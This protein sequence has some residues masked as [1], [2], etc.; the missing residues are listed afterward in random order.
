MSF[1]MRRL[2][3]IVLVLGGLFVAAP[4]AG[5]RF[6][7]ATWNVETAFDTIPAPGKEDK[8]YLPSSVMQWN[9]HRYWNKLK[10][11]SQTIA[12]MGL[13]E[14]IGVQEVENDTV[15]R[16][17]TRRTPL[18]KAGYKFVMTDSPDARGIDVGLLYR[19]DRFTLLSW[20]AIR[21]PS[22]SLGLR[23]TRDLLLASGRVCS[24]TLH[25]IVVH[26]PSRRSSSKATVQLRHA[27][28]S[29]LVETLCTLSGKK[30]LLMGDFNAE[31]GDRIFR[32]L[33]PYVTTLLPT[34]KKVLKGR[35]GTY[36]FRGVWGFLDHIMVSP[37]LLPYAAGEASECRYTW[38]L[39]GKNAIPRRTYGG[40]SYLG[41]ISDH[42]PLMATFQF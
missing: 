41:G 7:V 19:T 39:K 38:L 8:D 4:V 14:L 13:P 21:V 37:A 5:Q 40:T 34:D 28:V 36:Y 16:D 35:R 24:D 18:R 20:Q 9:S 11:L 30:V 25:V 6:C 23:P 27:V 1:E 17:L 42:L 10:N 33:S 2:F 3:C 31:P 26:L 15:L 12:A 29:T 32:Q 22:D